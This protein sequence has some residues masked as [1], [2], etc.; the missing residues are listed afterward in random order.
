MHRVQGLA[1]ILLPDNQGNVE[2]RRAL[3]NGNDIDPTAAQRTKELAG[4]APGLFHVLAHGRHNA[5]AFLQLRGIQLAGE[6]LK[7]KF[8]F[9]GLPGGGN[10]LRADGKGNAVLG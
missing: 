7:F 1:Q 6:Q 4:Q 3:C 5:A 8:P 10:I 2:L 9:N